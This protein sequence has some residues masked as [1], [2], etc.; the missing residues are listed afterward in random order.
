MGRSGLTIM[1]V[2]H[3]RDA[4][5]A[6]RQHPSIDAV[7]IA[8]GNTG[9]KSTIH[10]YLKELEEQEEQDGVKLADAE[11]LSAPIQT[12][13][14]QL[15]AQLHAEA[16][17]VVHAQVE[18]AAIDRQAAQVETGKLLRELNDLRAQLADT[19]T[20]LE[21]EQ[22]AH[23]EARDLLQKRTLENERL[24]QQVRDQNAR[25][26]EQEGF[27]QSL[28]EKLV[29]ARDALEH[30]RSAA[31]EL[32]EQE[33]RRHE[34]QIQQLQA[35][36]RQLNQSAIVKQNE[37]TQLNKDNARL[38]AEAGAAGKQLREQQ[39]LNER[40]Q[41]ALAQAAADAARGE[42]ERDSL[43]TSLQRQA[44]ELASLRES[45][46][47]LATARTEAAQA[48]E[49]SAQLRGQIEVVREQ[50]THLLRT[51]ETRFSEGGKDAS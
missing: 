51:I 14:A 12:L 7:R 20:A 33:I 45:L 32:R 26:A 24:A 48:R 46:P 11:S 41:A 16:Q 6:Q 25:A 30:F 50:Q 37:I 29:H 21:Q 17:A 1:D 9:S 40:Q 28:E 34:H 39:G 22:A 18:A 2:K 27:R 38:V 36:L 49:E 5:V 23:V 31:R 10:R 15:S 3:A 44:A 4:L 43:R 8:L 42:A 35:D 13:V 19:T 47:Q